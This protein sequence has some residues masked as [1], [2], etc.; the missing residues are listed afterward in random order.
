MTFHRK[1]IAQTSTDSPKIATEATGLSGPSLFLARAAWLVLVLGFLALFVASLPPYF[2]L[3]SHPCIGSSCQF[4]Q[5]IPAS[6]MSQLR[7]LGI[8]LDTYAVLQI[9]SQILLVSVFVAIASI[10]FW[11]KSDD[12]V[13]LLG[14]FTLAMF[15][16]LFEKGNLSLLPQVWALPVQCV[17][18]LSFTGFFIFFYLFPSGQFVPRWT[19]W[20]AGGYLLYWLTDEFLP[21][22]QN[23]PLNFVIFVGFI[24]SLFGVQ[25]YRYRRVSTLRERQQTRW[26]VIGAI[27]GIGG[28]LVIFTLL[29]IFL[30]GPPTNTSQPPLPLLLI[31]SAISLLILLFPLSVGF[32]ILRYRLWDIDILVNR[33]LV[34]SALT[35]TLGLAYAALIIGLQFLLHGIIAQS[36]EVI[37]VG[38]TLVIA[39]LF[40]PLRRRIQQMI[41]RR[42]YR[43]K[44][45]AAKTLAAFSAT[46]RE[47]VDLA[48]LSEQLV[49][50][51]QETMQP[52]HI[53]LWLQPGSKERQRTP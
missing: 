13:A 1:N 51:V 24:A 20:L 18:S 50:I 48:Q 33:A 17:A 7:S 3:L 49:T 53:S 11:R 16:I 52:T 5:V 31:N 15:G 32:A 6:E 37:L 25:V 42:F 34:Y 30:G 36:N 43:R 44:Y 10:I 35:I 22:W 38:S 21:I 14:S 39:A 8:S 47:E 45:D 46:L 41:D 9:S 19:R 29:Y 2:V 12:P 4:A 40:Q 27:A 28:Y 26:V 23:S